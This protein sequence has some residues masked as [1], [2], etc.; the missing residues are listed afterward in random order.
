MKRV[1][2]GVQPT[3]NIH[4]GNYL[5]AIR[6]FVELEKENDCLYC[7]VNMHSITVPQDPKALKEH[8]SDVAYGQTGSGHHQHKAPHSYQPYFKSYG[9]CKYP[10]AQS[11]EFQQQDKN[12]R[13]KD[14]S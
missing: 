5:G 2:S 4:I 11:P 14:C 9:I 6:Q 7:I 13:R 8:T 3:G 1:F 12:S 10:G